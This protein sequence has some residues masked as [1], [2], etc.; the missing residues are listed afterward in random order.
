MKSRLI[1]SCTNTKS[2]TAKGADSRNWSR[3]VVGVL[4]SALKWSIKLLNWAFT[5]FHFWGPQFRHPTKVLDSFKCK[6]LENNIYSNMFNSRLNRSLVHT[7]ISLPLHDQPPTSWGCTLQWTWTNN[8]SML[9]RKA[10]THIN[11]FWKVKRTRVHHPQCVVFLPRHHWECPHWWR[12]SL[13]SLIINVPL[14]SLFQTRLTNIVINITQT[15]T[16][17]HTPSLSP[18]RKLVPMPTGLFN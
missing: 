12:L 14:P 16:I 3:K 6:L 13:Q 17:P 1:S 11:L 5:K 4:W 7:L 18:T 15:P 9:V 10:Q 2:K 8:F